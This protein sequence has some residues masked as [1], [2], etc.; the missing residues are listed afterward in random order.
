[1]SGGEVSRTGSEFRERWAE[2]AYRVRKLGTAI[3]GKAFNSRAFSSSDLRQTHCNL[4]NRTVHELGTFQGVY[5]N[6]EPT[7]SR[8]PVGKTRI[9]ACTDSRKSEHRHQMSAGRVSRT[10]SEICEPCSERAPRPRTRNQNIWRRLQIL[11]FLVER[12]PTRPLQFAAPLSTRNR[13]MPDQ[14]ANSE[15]TPFR[16]PFAKARFSVHAD[17]RNSER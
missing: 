6:P 1:M 13:R 3:C 16:Q 12:S 10:G 17:S 4:Q 9:C 8:Q 14:Y 7:R 15:P 2:F 5:T 11:S